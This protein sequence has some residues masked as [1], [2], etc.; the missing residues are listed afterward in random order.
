MESTKG[1]PYLLGIL[2]IKSRHVEAVIMMTY[3]GKEKK[4]KVITTICSGFW[5]KNELKIGLKM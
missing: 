5:A 3:C 1:E 2:F 4:S